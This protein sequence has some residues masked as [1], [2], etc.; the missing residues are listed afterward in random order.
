MKRN[1]GIQS[2]FRNYEAAK[3]RKV[4][5]E[6][7]PEYIVSNIEDEAVHSPPPVHSAEIEFDIED[8]AVHSNAEIES[9][10]QD[11]AVHSP[12]AR[13]YNIQWLPPDSGERIPILEYDV[14][15]PDEV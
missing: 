15:D 7:Q 3:R 14:D 1:G 2:F 6:E 10:S 8:E 11:E 5:A 9:D 12:C 13:P 4:V